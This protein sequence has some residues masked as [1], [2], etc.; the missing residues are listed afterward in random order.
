MMN[1]DN[2]IP[3]SLIILDGKIWEQWPKQ[4]KSLFGF[5]ETLEVILN[6]V[7]KL[8]EHV[9]EAQRTIHKDTK[10]RDCKTL[11]CIQFVVDGANFNR[12]SHAEPEK[13]EWNI[14]VIYYEE[15]EKVKGVKLQALRRK[16]ELP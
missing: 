3:N 13:E 9:I 2:G 8:V 5:Q 1:G 7:P 6:G 14:I 12:I 15:G 10:K 11:F 4:I 16:Y